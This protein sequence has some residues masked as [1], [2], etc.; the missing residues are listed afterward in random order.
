MYHHGVV[1]IILLIWI[2][3]GCGCGAT[4]PNASNEAV[5]EGSTFLERFRA[6]ECLVH[7]ALIWMIILYLC[8]A[9]NGRIW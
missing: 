9:L 4:R 1:I 2:I 3:C 8:Y 7:S 6:M 5:S